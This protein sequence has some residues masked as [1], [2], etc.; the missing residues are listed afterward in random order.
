[1]DNNISQFEGVKNVTLGCDNG[2][3]SLSINKYNFPLEY[4]IFGSKSSTDYDVIVNIPEELTTIPCHNFYLISEKLD[5]VLVPLICKKEAKP[6]NTSFGHWVNNKLV[7][8]QK[9][10][11]SETNNAIYNTFKNH[12]QML[13]QSPINHNM[14]RTLSD[15][16]QKIMAASRMIIGIFTH[17][18]TDDDYI[19]KLLGAISNIPEISRLDTITKSRFLLTLFKIPDLKTS[20]YKTITSVLRDDE[21][22]KR[23]SLLK[24]IKNKWCK[25]NK[26]KIN[27]ALYRDTYNKLKTELD[28][29]KQ[30]VEYNKSAFSEK[31]LLSLEEELAGQKLSL[32]SVA[33]A[34]LIGKYACFRYEFLKLLDLSKI[35][36]CTDIN[37]K[38]KLIAFQA[39][40]T[41]CLL[42]NIEVFEKE[43]ISEYYPELK[44]FLFRHGT[45]N[46]KEL[47][48]CV[49]VLASSMFDFLE[50]TH[51]EQLL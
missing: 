51:I 5:K 36:L 3:Y 25:N 40:Q 17:A 19:F 41:N 13:K 33:R 27:F 20:T 4:C 49:Q 24:N 23:I 45:S 18:E 43:T 11:L 7:W 21:I 16:Q 14:V 29:I 8:C 34:V 26:D 9:G 28:I 42:M 31:F 37:D 15:K 2:C 39:G 22:D 47:N 32:R 44:P 12:E 1:M 6:I 48:S 50:R 38:L 30:L 35:Y 46:Y 10:V